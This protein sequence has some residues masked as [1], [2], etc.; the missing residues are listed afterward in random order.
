[1]NTNFKLI[2]ILSCFVTL[3]VLI[4]L[5]MTRDKFV[6]KSIKPKFKETLE[7][8]RRA[9]NTIGVKFHLHSGTALGA[10]REKD[11]IKHDNDI[12]LAIF[13]EDYKDEIINSMKK[14]FDFVQ[15]YG[16]I[17]DG[18]ELK[19]IHKKNKIN[20][21]IFLI[22]KHGNK[23]KQSVYHCKSNRFEKG[24][25]PN[26]ECIMYMNNYQPILTEFLG[27]KYYCAPITFLEDR[28]GKDWRIPKI[29]QYD[30][31]LDMHY[32]NV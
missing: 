4:V 25:N 6:K 7:D 29:F 31:G 13:K 24:N 28:Y 14:Y 8:A 18:L 17:E 11:F 16:E 22:Y 21:D 30:E 19:F 12:D 23:L 2:F 5:F 9:I 27:E 15:R 3:I 20:L 32:G 26:D 1:M 10:L